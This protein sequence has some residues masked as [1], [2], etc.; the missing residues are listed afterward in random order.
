MSNEARI[1]FGSSFILVSVMCTLLEVLALELVPG[2]GNGR[3]HRLDQTADVARFSRHGVI[4]A[5]STATSLRLADLWRAYNAFF[6]KG[7]LHFIR[8]GK[9]I[10][11]QLKTR[12]KVISKHHL[13]HPKLK[14]TK[15]IENRKQSSSKSLTIHPQV[16]D[17]GNLRKALHRRPAQVLAGVIGAEVANGQLGAAAAAQHIA[18]TVDCHPTTSSAAP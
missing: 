18:A 8:Q 5:A 10:T 14:N 9:I 17:G 4:T 13:F 6:P 1:R 15:K 16:D 3:G 2:N 11:I 12:E 7:R